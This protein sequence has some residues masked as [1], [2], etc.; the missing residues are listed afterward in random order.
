ML[1]AVTPLT[2]H[3]ASR[4]EA[5]GMDSSGVTKENVPADQVE[6]AIRHLPSLDGYHLTAHIPTPFMA[7]VLRNPPRHEIVRLRV[8]DSQVDLLRDST[9][10]PG[11][12]GVSCSPDGDQVPVDT[13]NIEFRDYN[14][15]C[16]DRGIVWVLPGNPGKMYFIIKS[17]ALQTAGEVTR[18]VAQAEEAV[19]TKLFVH[20]PE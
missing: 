12:I 10:D 14:D 6:E 11:D 17:P 20:F 3:G 16:T 18:I 2:I 15:D 8:G 7:E 1:Y 5:M 19:Q 13:L 9:H 4:K